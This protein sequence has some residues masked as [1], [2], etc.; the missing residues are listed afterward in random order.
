MNR[1]HVNYLLVGGGIAASEAVRAIRRR[2]RSGS[3]TLVT[4]ESIRT[5]Q[6]PELSKRYLRRELQRSQIVTAADEWFR[7]QDVELRS[8]RRATRIEVDRHSVVLDT[9]DVVVY[10]KLLLAV[11]ATARPLGIPGANLPGVHYL[12]TL[13]DA[14]RLLHAIDATRIDGLPASDDKSRRGRVTVIGAGV[15]GVEVAASLRQIGLHVDLVVGRP[16]V[17]NRYAGE[18]V[19]RHVARQLEQGGVHVHLEVA[20]RIEGDGRVQRVLLAGGKTI[21][22]NLVVACVGMEA[23]RELLTGTPISAE[24]AILVDERC[25]TNVPDVFAAGDCCAAFDPLFGKH[26]QFAH[27]HHAQRLGTI[28]GDVMAGGSDRLDDVVTFETRYFDHS[29]RFWGEP[30]LIDRR[31]IR[32]TNGGDV[33]EFGVARDGRLAQAIAIGS[34]VVDGH[35]RELVRSRFQVSGFEDQLRDPQQPLP[36]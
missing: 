33:I 7:E 8:G 21:D 4:R 35:L 2:D 1:Q 10:D 5:Y 31:L 14:D 13:D 26:R 18:V 15:L 20:T 3:I 19:G 27:W 9:S 36:R 28:A 22:T 16:H 6:R 32:Q 25:R 24:R 17:W 12:R 29:A 11:G 23:N 30:R 34:D